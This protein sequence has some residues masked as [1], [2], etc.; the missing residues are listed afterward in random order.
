MEFWP[1]GVSL[2]LI[3]GYGVVPNSGVIHSVMDSGGTR[4]RRRFKSV[5][6]KVNAKLTIDF[7]AL[8]IFEHWKLNKI[9]SGA[10][11][12]LMDVKLATGIEQCEAKIL[13]QGALK[14]L[15]NKLWSMSL[16]F[17]IKSAPVPNDES[18]L[19]LQSHGLLAIEK[20]ANRADDLEIL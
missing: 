15:S 16:E 6:F 18:V 8:S 11:W 13:K 20:A 4:S 7:E 14:P 19:I 3:N 1:V 10:S 5:P 12:F 9:D 2:P 17:L